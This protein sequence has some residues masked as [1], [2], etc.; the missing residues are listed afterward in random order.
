MCLHRNLLCSGS[1]LGHIA[2]W[3]LEERRLQSQIRDAHASSVTGACR[4]AHTCHS[5]VLGYD[6]GIVR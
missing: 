5:L 3:D 6:T 2:Q 4:A 1:V